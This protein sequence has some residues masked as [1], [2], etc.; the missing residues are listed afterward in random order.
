MCG[1]GKRMK[2]IMSDPVVRGKF[3]RRNYESGKPIPSWVSKEEALDSVYSDLAKQIQITVETPR[4][5]RSFPVAP[6]NHTPFEEDK[7]QVSKINF[8]KLQVVP[9]K[10]T[11]F[12]IDGLTFGV[13]RMHIE[14]P[15]MIKHSV[16]S[17]PEFKCGY[18]DSSAS[19]KEGIPNLS[20]SGSQ[21]FIPWGDKSKYHYLCRTWYGLIEYLAQQHILPNVNISLGAFS[22]SSKV[23]RGLEDSRKLLLNPAF[24]NTYMDINALSELVSG[25]KSVLF[26]VSDGEIA[27]WEE[28]KD[29]FV[30]TVRDHFYFHIQ[31]GKSTE[32]TKDVK[33]AGLHVYHVNTGEE[34]ERMAIDLTSAAYQTY[35]ADVLEK[36]K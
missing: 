18:F 21:T 19:M 25:S 5:E 14:S 24:G 10:D 29:S 35:I 20:D 1:F 3:A 32:M 34:L 23:V 36:T 27:N 12:G 22:D 15:L 11:P 13:P 2:E 9:E 4:K 28:V 6:F 16:T 33:N 8:R 7:D 26:T 31:I 30:S 17:F